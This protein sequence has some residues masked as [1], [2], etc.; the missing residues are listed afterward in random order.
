MMEREDM[1]VM[2]VTA[3]SARSRHTHNA[4]H[5]RLASG[6]HREG[7][8]LTLNCG[9]S[10]LKFALFTRQTEPRRIL[11]GSVTNIGGDNSR[12][13]A[14]DADG[15]VLWDEEETCVNHPAAIDSAMNRL[16]HTEQIGAIG[17]VGHRVVHG[18]PDCDC[19]EP[20]TAQLEARLHRLIPLAPLHLPA[21]L[22]GIVAARLR[23][24]DAHHV[25]CFDTAF[26]HS[27]PLN[28]RCTGLPRDIEQDEIRRYGYHG[29]S[30]EFIVE[31]IRQS[32][33]VQAL[34]ARMIVAHLGAGAS[35][36]AIQNG[37]SIDTT[38]G[39]STAA[40]LPM[41]TRSGDI[42]PGLLVYL[43]LEK[44]WSAGEL[45]ALIYERSGLLGLSG[46]TGDMA[47]LTA[48]DADEDARQ[49]VDYFCYQARKYIGALAAA[50][51]GVDRIIFTGGIGENSPE[52]RARIC[53]PLEAA[54]PMALDE[55][56][57]A[58]GGPVISRD[59]SAIRLDVL[60]TDEELM[61][62]RHTAALASERSASAWASS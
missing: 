1:S 13:H 27:A 37:R 23:L 38:M 4:S 54:F 44:G 26:H 8:I 10:S 3:D 51:G 5:M 56:L 31:H 39:F 40:G 12:S 41:A 22:N 21:N 30:Y 18:G 2:S 42:D 14:V 20:V 9:S 24:P 61:I 35:M 16:E 43:L 17:F 32:E 55:T 60:P 49:A 52:I 19:P 62:A 6:A 25:A 33:G 48:P 15:A 50:M 36:A 34:E 53:T 7:A 29:L 45:Q 57:N 11:S 46:Q 58:A 28:A 47:V 59:A